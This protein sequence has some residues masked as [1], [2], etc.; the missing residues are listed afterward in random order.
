MVLVFGEALFDIFPR[1]SRPGGAPFNFAWHCARF[2]LDVRFASRVGNDD[3]GRDL[4]ELMKSGGMSTELMQV[5]AR[6]D[7]GRVIVTLDVA[8]VPAFDIVEQAAY[9]FIEVGDALVSAAKNAGSSIR[10]RSSGGQD[11][12]RH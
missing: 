9:D 12:R 6:H 2:G 7:T 3:Y 8:G 5:D 11:R 4:Q 1:Y 10:A